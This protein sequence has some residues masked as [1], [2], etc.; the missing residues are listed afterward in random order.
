[1]IFH[2]DTMGG[3]TCRGGDPAAGA[4]TS[5][6]ERGGQNPLHQS[7]GAHGPAQ[8]ISGDLPVRKGE[9]ATQNMRIPQLP[10]LEG[11]EQIKHS[12]RPGTPRHD[13]HTKTN[14]TG[15]RRRERE[16]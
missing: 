5:N 9:Q 4:T 11:E 16:A 6:R 15:R 2:L 12:G 7:Q 8:G 14:K 10:A 1:M 3:Y 13:M